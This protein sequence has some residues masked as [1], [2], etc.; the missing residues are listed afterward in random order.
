MSEFTICGDSTHLP[1]AWT[2]TFAAV[3]TSPCLAP[4]ERVLTADLRWIPAGDV[5]VGDQLLT[6]NEVP[7]GVNSLGRASRRKYEIATVEQA[8]GAK[9]E[10]V[11]ISLNTGE[12]IDCSADHPWLA[13]RYE[14]TSRP[15]EWVRADQLQG[16]FVL[17]QFDTWSPAVTYEAGWL[18]GMYDGEGSI[19]F[20]THGA[21][22]LTMTQVTGSL[23]TAFESEMKSL[24]FKTTGYPKVIG[25]QILTFHANGGVPDILKILGTLRPQRLIANL[26]K[27]NGIETCT[28][29]PRKEK[30]IS[31]QKLGVRDIAGIQTSTGTYIGEGYLMHNTY[32]NRM[33]DHHEAKDDS[34]RNTYRHTLGRPL[35][36]NNTGQYQSTQQNYWDLHEDVYTQCWRVIEP[37]GLMI[38][39]VSNH[40]RQGK[41][42]DVCSMHKKIL[43]DIGFKL[44]TRE[45]VATPR[46]GFGQNG[47]LRVEKEMIYVYRKVL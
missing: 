7:P 35:S 25:S 37:D 22:K 44:I 6:F 39:N 30:V 19:Y 15:A 24:G 47:Q 3:V 1:D 13:T 27:N 46:N 38:V 21:P 5:Q 23:A 43:S 34:K 4:Y 20:G 33:A 10:S 45:E 31:V 16:W 11:R 12:Q 40:I 17:H 41:E 32:G 18:A 36:T 42:V 29:Q 9:K 26:N 8:Y 28:I 2:N 14:D